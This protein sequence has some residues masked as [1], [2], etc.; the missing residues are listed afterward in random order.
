MVFGLFNL[1]RKKKSINYKG[2]KYTLSE[3]NALTMGNWLKAMDEKDKEI[4][5]SK[6]KSDEYDLKSIDEN[7]LD[8]ELTEKEKKE[9]KTWKTKQKASSWKS[10]Q[11]KLRKEGKLEQYKIEA[12]NRMG[13]SWDRENNE[14]EHYFEIFKIYGLCAAIEDWTKEQRDLFSKNKLERENLIRLQAVNF[15]FFSKKNEVFEIT[16]FQAFDMINAIKNGQKEYK[17]IAI[18]PKTK[19][20]NLR[21]QDKKE[22]KISDR[23]IKKLQNEIDFLFNRKKSPKGHGLDR[24]VVEDIY[25]DAFKYL[26][27]YYTDKKGKKVKFVCPDEVKIYAAEKTIELL[28]SKILKTRLLS[29]VKQIPAIAKYISYYD[30][31][32]NEEKMIYINNLIKKYALLRQIY[33]ERIDRVMKKYI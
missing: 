32:R 9:F 19:T 5:K 13:M 17:Y 6:V 23:E 18:K 33:G 8:L 29:R 20:P 12:L 1:F 25:F 16:S 28:E 27:G 3:L 30:K 4:E 7:N 11:R 26:R 10:R 24:N 2:K 31:E 14:W 21:K 15:P 22:P